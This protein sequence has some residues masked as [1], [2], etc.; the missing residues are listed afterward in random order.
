[1]LTAVPALMYAENVYVR[2]FDASVIVPF[3]G[4]DE[5]VDVSAV[6]DGVPAVP[7]GTLIVNAVS[8]A[9]L[10]VVKL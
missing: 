2:V 6:T 8:P 10:A 5:L 4:T 7:G 1:M 3:V 9:P